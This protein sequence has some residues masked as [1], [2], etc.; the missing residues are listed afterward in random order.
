MTIGPKKIA[1]VTINGYDKKDYQ[2]VLHNVTGI[3][4]VEDP[5]AGTFMVIDYMKDNTE[6]C[7]GWAAKH[8]SSVNLK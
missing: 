8:T 4:E 7:F 3:R 2:R 5:Y 1:E 6:H